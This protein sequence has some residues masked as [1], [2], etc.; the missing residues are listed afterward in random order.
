MR[1]PLISIP[2]GELSAKDFEA[3]D[4]A[5]LLPCLV[6]PAVKGGM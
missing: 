6:W 2:T 4:D 5:E 1:R 3:D